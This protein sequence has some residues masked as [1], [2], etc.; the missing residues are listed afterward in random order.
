MSTR[1]ETRGQVRRYLAV[2]AGLAVSALAGCGPG[3]LSNRPAPGD[4]GQA[5]SIGDVGAAGVPSL[6]GA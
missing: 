3:G 1:A 5:G 2:L 4:A 6:G